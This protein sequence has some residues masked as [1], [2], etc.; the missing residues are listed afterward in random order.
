MATKKIEIA[1]VKKMTSAEISKYIIEITQTK[2]CAD[3]KYCNELIKIYL[4]K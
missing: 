3:K 4:S 2:I 1:E